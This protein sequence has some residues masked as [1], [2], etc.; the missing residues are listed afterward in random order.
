MT[1]NGHGLT[2][3]EK[4]ILITFQDQ[5]STNIGIWQCSMKPMT[6]D[7]YLCSENEYREERQRLGMSTLTYLEDKD[8]IRLPSL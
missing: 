6:R 4:I 2:F 7:R 1:S 3:M 5:G 8:N